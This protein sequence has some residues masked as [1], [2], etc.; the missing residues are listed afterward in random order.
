MRPSNKAQSQRGNVFLFIL[1]GIILFAGLAFVISRGFRS[2]GTQKISDRRAELAATDIL[3]YTQRLER[4]I[5]KIRSKSVSESDI[6][7]EH[8]GEFI[9]ASCDD[10]GDAAFPACQVF[11]P[12]GGSLSPQDPPQDANDGSPWHFTGAS[13]IPDIGTGAAGCDSSGADEELLAVLPNMDAT[14]CEE[15]NKKLKITG[16]PADGGGGHAATPFTGTF[17]DGTEID[18]PGGPFSAACFS[19]GGANHFYAVIMAR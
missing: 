2:E 9:N 14:V 6:S 10:S 7:L 13:C 5:N 3:S 1:L 12:G 17:A 11:N 18:L 19:S 15:L 8:G 16:I 4:A